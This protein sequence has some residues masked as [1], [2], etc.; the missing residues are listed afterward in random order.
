MPPVQKRKLDPLPKKNRHLRKVVRTKRKRSRKRKRKKKVET[1]C[2][3]VPPASLV[4]PQNEEDEAVDN[5]LTLLS[6]SEDDSD[7]PSKDRL[8]SQ[9]D[10]G[11]CVMHQ[12]CLIQPCEFS[13]SQE[14]GPS[15]PA[16]TSLASPPCCFGRF[17]SCVCQTFSR[18]RKRKS[19]RE[20]TQQAEGGRFWAKT[21]FIVFS[22]SLFL[23]VEFLSLPHLQELFFFLLFTC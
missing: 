8:Q 15:S 12:E 3:G 14:L 6:A 20:S 4:P 11:T 7:L 2:P 9:Q 10:E 13:V 23:L 17:L 19:G 21:N 18:S 22:M 1:H 5:K 16:E